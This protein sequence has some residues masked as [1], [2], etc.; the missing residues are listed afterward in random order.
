MY[1]N[2]GVVNFNG[3]NFPEGLSDNLKSVVS[4]LLDKE[5]SGDFV[6]SSSVADWEEQRSVIAPLNLS[7]SE[8]SNYF[9]VGVVSFPFLGQSTI[10]L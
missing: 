7:Y 8:K 9:L 6:Y 2:M 4:F 5:A 3:R 1:D 10:R